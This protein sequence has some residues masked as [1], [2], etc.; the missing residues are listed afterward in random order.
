MDLKLLLE[1][2]KTV[3]VPVALL[4]LILWYIGKRLM[5]RMLTQVDKDREILVQQLKHGRETFEKTTAAQLE[6]F[7]REMKDQRGSDQE[8]RQKDRAIFQ[9]VIRQVCDNSEKAT[10]EVTKA[11]S[12]LATGVCADLKGVTTIVQDCRG[13]KGNGD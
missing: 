9:D 12:D 3:G 8:T 4:L 5:P 1:F 11:V 10:K 2:A 7:Q 13:R 6:A